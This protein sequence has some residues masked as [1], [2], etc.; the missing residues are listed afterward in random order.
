MAEKENIK[1]STEEKYRIKNIYDN[2]GEDFETVLKKV[3][4]STYSCIKHKNDIKYF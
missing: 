3:I 4:L 2:N 1:T